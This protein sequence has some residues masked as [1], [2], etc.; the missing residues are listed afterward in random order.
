MRHK[1]TC[2]GKKDALLGS[3]NT[4]QATITASYILAKEKGNDAGPYNCPECGVKF[5]NLKTQNHCKTF[6]SVI[7]TLQCTLCN[8]SWRNKC[9]L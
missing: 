1:E 7:G 9:D 6:N 3:N 5:V 4:V 8:K 2:T